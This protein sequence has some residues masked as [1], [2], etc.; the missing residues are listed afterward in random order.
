MRHI[1]SYCNEMQQLEST[2]VS[3]FCVILCNIP[4]E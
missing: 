2:P 1:N 3:Y 4:S